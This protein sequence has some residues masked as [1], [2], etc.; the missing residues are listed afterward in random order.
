MK[1]S[2]LPNYHIEINNISDSLAH[3]HTGTAVSLHKANKYLC[4]SNTNNPLCQGSMVGA[5]VLDFN[6]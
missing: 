5:K 4:V 2:W 6:P 3:T 1:T